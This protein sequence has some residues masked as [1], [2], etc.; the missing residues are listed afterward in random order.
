MEVPL[1]LSEAPYPFSLLQV[2][3]YSSTVRSRCLRTCLAYQTLCTGQSG[4]P[5]PHIL[6]GLSLGLSLKLP[7]QSFLSLLLVPVAL[8]L[9][10]TPCPLQSE[11]MLLSSTLDCPQIDHSLI[12]LIQVRA[13]LLQDVPPVLREAEPSDKDQDLP[14]IRDDD[15]CRGEGCIHLL[16]FIHVALEV[17]PLPQ[18]IK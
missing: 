16:E 8:C 12:H 4:V 3:L 14:L 2:C 11:A 13:L 17:R 1:W 18:T 7:Q 15:P 10:L 6:P 5:S 9:H